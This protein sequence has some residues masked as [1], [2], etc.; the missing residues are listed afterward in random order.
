MTRIHGRIGKL[1]TLNLI[2]FPSPTVFSLAPLTQKNQE[3]DKN[4]TENHLKMVKYTHHELRN[5]RN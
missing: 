2:L 5:N 1:L 4:T 3:T